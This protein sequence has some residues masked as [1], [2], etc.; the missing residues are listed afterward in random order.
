MVGCTQ[1]PSLVPHEADAV[2]LVPLLLKECCVCS[3]RPRAGIVTWG[4]ELMF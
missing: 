1:W 3:L 2:P 4:L